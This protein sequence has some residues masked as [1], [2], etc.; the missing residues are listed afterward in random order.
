MKTRFAFIMLTCV[1]LFVSGCGSSA[2]IPIIGS[3][4]QSLIVGKWEAGEVG[5]LITAE[6][7]KD[8]KANLTMFGRTLE[9]TYKMPSDDEMEW[10]LNGKTTKY[11]VKVTATTLVVTSEGK[12][13]TYKKA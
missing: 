11:K 8:G 12:T 10:T 9:G 3:S 1:V 7:S 5:G 13:V 6:F 4:P 2:Q